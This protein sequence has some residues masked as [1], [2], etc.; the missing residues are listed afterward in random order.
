MDAVAQRFAGDDAVA[1]DRLAGHPLDEED[2]A[3]DL[4]EH[5][6][7][8]GER[9]RVGVDDVVAQHDPERLVADR[10][11]ADEHR[12]AQSQRLVLEHRRQRDA[13]GEL[14][15]AVQQRRFAAPGELR[16]E[17][18]VPA[19][20]VFEYPLPGAVHQNDLRQTGRDRL[21]D[22]VLDDRLVDDWQQLL[23]EHRGGRQDAGPES[24]RGEHDFPNRVGGRHRGA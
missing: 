15:Q 17:G 12:V 13:G 1:A 24:G 6:Q 18:R 7:H 22:A 11:A 14:A 21:L 3:V 10:L 23:G 5:R 8:L 16:V 20:M 4:C 9:G 2:R 19:E